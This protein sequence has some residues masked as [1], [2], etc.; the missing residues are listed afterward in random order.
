MVKG[1]DIALLEQNKARAAQTTGV[2][3]DDSLEQAFQEVT[4]ESSVPKKRTRE[5]IIKELKEK[6]QQGGVED[7]AKDEAVLL[8]EAKKAGKFKPIGFKPI[9]APAE[10][11]KKKKKTGEIEKDGGRKK[12]KRKVDAGNLDTREEE[13]PPPSIPVDISPPKPTVSEPEPEPEPIPEDFDI[14]AGAEVYEGV[15]LGDDDEEEE[16]QMQETPI[17]EQHQESVPRAQWFT[18]D[19]PG[20]D[21]KPQQPDLTQL[22]KTVSNS[23]SPPAQSAMDED[24]EETGHPTRLVPLSSSAIPSIKELLAMDGAQDKKKKWK[25]KKKGPG[26]KEVDPE[27]QKKATAEA[28][29]ERDY[30][31]SVPVFPCMLSRKL[32]RDFACRRLKTYTEKKKAGAPATKGS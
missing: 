18:D 2:D 26:G 10:A 6:R 8:E 7:V 25:D 9:G 14:F 17:P 11:K 5:D 15:D 19:V 13:M 31:R 30:K 29:A 20:E 1:L 3:D 4:T 21:R 22:N 16:G 12:K 28:K 24:D 23:H 27:D 32:T